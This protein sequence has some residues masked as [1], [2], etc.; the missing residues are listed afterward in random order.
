MDINELLQKAHSLEASD[1]HIKVGS[2]PILRIFGELT[3]LTSEK[4]VSHDDAYV[5]AQSVMNPVQAEI[6]KK[7]NDLDLA[8]SVPGLGRFR[9]NIFMQRGTV[10]IVFRVIPMT[11]P[12]ID[13]L[14][15]PEVIKKICTEQ[16]GLILV[17][18]TTGSGKSTTLAAMIDLI[19][20]SRTEH[21]ITIEDPIEYLHRDKK[22]IINQREIG[23]DSE[24]F[25]K[26]L[27]QS[28]RQ[29]PDVI[30]VGEMRDFETIQTSLVAAE[31]GHLVLSTLHTIDATETINRIITVFPPYQHKQVRLQ[32]ASVLRAIISMRLMPRADGRG[33]VPAVEVMIATT[34]IK[35]LIID[36]DKTKLIPDMI[37]QSAIHYHMQTFDQSLLKLFNAG[38]ITYEEALRR[39]T[40]PDDFV[41]KVKGVQSTSDL[42]IEE[43]LSFR[44]DK[45]ENKGK[46]DIDR[47]GR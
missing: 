45:L 33:R 42:S 35:D 10:G 21:I 6:F 40:N 39:A 29:D 1:L 37:E 25:G 19:N 24:S 12:S 41:L 5:I 46:M 11:I 47:F 15:L 22:S 8:Y 13:E 34:T 17:T 16:R 43:Q 31:T 38:L 4:R 27:R 9:C 28:L 44:P 7:K 36:P 18:G 30:L 23:T 14:L 26:A 32:L 20:S 3:P 2:P